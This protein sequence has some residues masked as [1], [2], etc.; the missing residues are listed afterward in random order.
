M[1]AALLESATGTQ[2]SGRRRGSFGVVL[3]VYSTQNYASWAI[4][5]PSD[6]IRT[7]DC[8]GSAHHNMSDRLSR[9]R[10]AG[11]AWFGRS[12]R[13]M[14]GANRYGVFFSFD[15]WVAVRC[16]VCGEKAWH[17]SDKMVLYDQNE[18]GEHAG[19]L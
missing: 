9:G 5:R 18:G 14:E 10:R 6:R 17:H 11:T 2:G 7:C 19:S 16:T 15:I 4:A 12:L 1:Q 13:P 3:A 8:H